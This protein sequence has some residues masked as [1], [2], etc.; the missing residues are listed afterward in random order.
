MIGLTETYDKFNALNSGASQKTSSSLAATEIASLKKKTNTELDKALKEIDSTELK[1]I[2]SSFPLIATDTVNSFQL[3]TPKL[4]AFLSF[5][6]RYPTATIDDALDSLHYEKTFLNRFLYERMTVA[7][8]IFSKKEN[9]EEFSQQIISH[10][11]ISLFVFLPLFTL[12][13]KLFYIRKKYTYVEHL[14]FVF[15]TQTVFFLLLAAFFMINYIKDAEYIMAIFFL[16]FLG[17]LFKAMRRFYQQG[18]FKTTVKFIL[19]NIVYLTFAIIGMVTVSFI[20]FAL[21]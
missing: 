10:I 2:K 16:L 8:A 12:F 11:S 15:H 6:E 3:S 9:R 19:L 21:Y 14:V 18:Y 17:Y 13:L 4:D 1:K 7:N 20:S 5:R